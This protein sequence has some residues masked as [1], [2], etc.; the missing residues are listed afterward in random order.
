MKKKCE[1]RVKFFPGRQSRQGSTSL[2]PPL[3]ATACG[4]LFTSL[5]ADH[6]YFVSIA[7]DLW[8]GFVF[9]AFYPSFNNFYWKII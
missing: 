4:L 7:L 8:N 2:G 6:F 5:L 3:A 9:P 1:L